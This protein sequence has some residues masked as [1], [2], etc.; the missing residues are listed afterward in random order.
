MRRRGKME[1]NGN[2]EQEEKIP[3]LSRG[4]GW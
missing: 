4:C 2:G 3:N 1:K